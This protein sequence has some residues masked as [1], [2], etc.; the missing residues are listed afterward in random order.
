MTLCWVDLETTGLPPASKRQILEIA[1]I[2]T[3]DNLVEVARMEE[4]MHFSDAAL[5]WGL[6]DDAARA[7]GK[8]IDI[9]PVVV[10]MHRKNGLWFRCEHATTDIHA[11]DIRLAALLA[12]NSIKDREY[13]DEKTG[14]TKK[15]RDHAQLAGSTISFDREFMRVHMPVSESLLHY[16]NLDVSSINEIARRFWPEVFATRPR[17][18][19]AGHRALGDIEQSIAVLKHYIANISPTRTARAAYEKYVAHSGGLNYLGQPCPAWD[20]LPEAIRG[21]WLAVVS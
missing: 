14:L 1:V 2:I 9:D 11:T 18:P 19:E 20:D 7:F 3:D 17:L 5:L 8:S 13:I 15:V 12:E 21:H 4:V 16:R 10:D 6:P